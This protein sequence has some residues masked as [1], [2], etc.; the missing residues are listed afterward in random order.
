MAM[1]ALSFAAATPRYLSDLIRHA[2]TEATGIP[3]AHLPDAPLRRSTDQPGQYL[4]PL[5]SRLAGRLGRAARDLAA[6]ITAVLRNQPHLT[7]VQVT[8]PGFVAVTPVPSMRAALA[9]LVADAPAAFLL[10]LAVPGVAHQPG[11][12]PDGWAL[13]DLAHARDSG[14]LRDWARADARRRIA[15]AA[16]PAT[17]PAAAAALTRQPPADWRDVPQDNTATE[18]AQLLTVIGEAAARVAACRSAAD[19]VRPQETTGPDL[20]ARPSPHAPGAWARATA[21]NPAFAL[22]YAHAHAHTAVHHWAAQLGL[23]RLGTRRRH[24]ADEVAALTTPAA[25]ALLGTLFDGPAALRAA[26]R[27]HQPHI[28]VRYLESLAAAYHEWWE[29]HSVLPGHEGTADTHTT[30]VAAR[31]D[32]CA[33]AAGVLRAGLLLIGVSAPTRL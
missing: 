2:C 1:T 26:A 16:D 21:A 11:P 10:D 20:P 19:Q 28:L 32:L 23:R 33:A 30:T 15:A 7:D 22:R 8:G 3:A 9:Q 24:T 29:S 17:A 14:Q 18:A 12:P 27:R 31:L 6:D 13:S 5:P 25:E 4:S